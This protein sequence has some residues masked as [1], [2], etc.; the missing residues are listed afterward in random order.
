[1]YPPVPRVT[2]NRDMQSYS[3]RHFWLNFHV[4]YA[5][6]HSGACCTSGWPIPVEHDRVIPIRSLAAPANTSWL[7]ADAHAPAEMAGT[8]A[9]RPNGECTFF[10]IPTPLRA[11]A[12]AGQ[13]SSVG[14]SGGAAPAVAGCAVHPARPSSCCHFP[15]V[16]LID[17]RG[18]HVT[19]S[20]YCPTAAAMLFEH[21]AP[22]EIV[23]GP[24][25]VAGFDVPEG[26][27]ARDSLPPLETPNR[28]MTF[29]AFTAWERTAIGEVPVSV[30]PA[31]SIDR[32]E[33]VRR[34]VP[35]PWS[36]PEA[37]PDFAQ[38]WQ[39]LAAAR[40]SAFA[41]VVRRYRAAKI[42][43]SWA[44]YHGDGRL[45]VIRLADLADAALRV[46][47]VRQCLQANRALDAELLKQAVRR[48]DLL[49]VHYADG[50]VLSSGTAP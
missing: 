45:A 33:C 47:A 38:Q 27:D 2:S 39:A 20:H 24:S 36:W 18:V 28:L 9:V 19:L 17:P 10:R 29:D 23:Q 14:P 21:L 37:P 40:W 3:V 5:C 22:I 48:A 30:S 34:S 31:V 35:Q 46:E 41:P 32:F 43:A 1:V 50:R 26:L 13:A 44:A 49:L 15:F 42:F 12:S 11:D 25:P 4:G 8:L 7:I 6:R 16:C